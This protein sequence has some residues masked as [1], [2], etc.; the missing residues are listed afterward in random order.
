VTGVGGGTTPWM[1]GRF[2]R[3]Y[4]AKAQGCLQSHPAPMLEGMHR[5]RKLF[6]F[7]LTAALLAAGVEFSPVRATEPLRS[8]RIATGLQQM[9]PHRGTQ[10]D[11]LLDGCK[12]SPECAAWLQSG[13]SP[14]LAGRDPA[15]HS[16]IEDVEDLADGDTLRKVGITTTYAQ[17]LPAGIHWGRI[18]VEFWGRDCAPVRERRWYVS[19]CSSKWCWRNTTLVVPVDAT[20]MTVTSSQDNVDLVWTLT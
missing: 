17:G 8:G 9:Q 3:G 11:L 10:A 7:A 2:A 13:C 19:S 5:Q 12:A 4:P 14:A 15:I 18:A 1:L 20:W 6:L 16:S